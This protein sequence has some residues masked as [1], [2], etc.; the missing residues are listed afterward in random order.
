MRA[1]LNMENQLPTIIQNEGLPKGVNFIPKN[2]L[3]GLPKFILIA[4]VVIIGAEVIWGIWYLSRP[5]PQTPKEQTKK[6]LFTEANPK[7]SLALSSSQ[8]KAQVGNNVAVTIILDSGNRKL[9]GVDLVIKYNPKV[10]S[11]TADSFQKGSIF[12]EYTGQN[13]NATTGTFSIS[14]LSKVSSEKENKDGILGTLTFKAIAKGQSEVIIDYKEDE[15]TDSNVIDSKLSKDILEK[16]TNLTV[17]V[18]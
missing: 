12:S 13:I 3:G 4:L 9:D 2:F 11:L 8:T 6:A 15:T 14:S 1:G 7:A 10:L 16:V 5:L 17:S 18:N